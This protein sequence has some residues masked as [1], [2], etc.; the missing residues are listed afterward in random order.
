MN[1]LNVV[2]ASLLHLYLSHHWRIHT[3][4]NFHRCNECEK[5]FSQRNYLV[6]HQIHSMQKA[7]EC[8]QC[9]CGGEGREVEGGRIHSYFNPHSK[10]KNPYPRK[11]FESRSSSLFNHQ[12]IYTR[13]ESDIMQM[14]EFT[15]IF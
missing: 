8:D 9:M 10:S 12:N 11:P 13:P 15:A 1:I 2:N 7:Y 4:I 3:R 6:Q 14:E 5:A